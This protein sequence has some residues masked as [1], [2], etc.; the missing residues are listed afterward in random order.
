VCSVV[1]ALCRVRHRLADAW[2]LTVDV[3]EYMDFLASLF[4]RIAAQPLVR[5]TAHGLWYWRHEKDV[6][7][8]SYADDLAARSEQ[9]SKRRAAR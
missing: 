7:A 1:C 6:T 3:N 8:G 4:E 2:T 9:L 5:H